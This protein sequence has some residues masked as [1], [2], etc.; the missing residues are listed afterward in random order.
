M[1]IAF[2][3]NFSTLSVGEPETARAL[4]ELGHQVVRLPERST[5]PDEVRQAM[6]DCDML[7]INKFRILASPLER[8]ELM[9][10]IK[11]PVVAQLFDLYFG[12]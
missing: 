6:K 12:L 5:T 3:G 7:L 8:L 11:K 2:V 9:R 1:K 4:E 10:E